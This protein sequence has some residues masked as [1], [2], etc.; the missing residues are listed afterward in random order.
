MNSENR[1]SQKSF[2]RLACGA[3]RD[4]TDDI[5]LAKHALSQLSYSPVGIRY[6]STPLARVGLRELQP[7]LYG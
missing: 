3:G 5:V 7:R 1:S 2:W 4:R 6:L